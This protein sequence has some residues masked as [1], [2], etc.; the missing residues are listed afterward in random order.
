MLELLEEAYAAHDPAIELLKLEYKTE[1]EE[2]ERQLKMPE[3]D[4]TVIF[5]ILEKIKE[6]LSLSVAIRELVNQLLL[7]DK[8]DSD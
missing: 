7:D 8:A 5:P 4:L 3:L 2:L 6:G 1:V